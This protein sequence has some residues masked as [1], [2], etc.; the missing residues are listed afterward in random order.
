DAGDSS[1][2]SG[3]LFRA[4]QTGINLNSFSFSIESAYGLNNQLFEGYPANLI[5]EKLDST[6]LNDSLEL[7]MNYSGSALSTVDYAALPDTVLIPPGF[8]SISFP[9]IVFAD[10]LA[11]GT[12][13]L[14]IQTGFPCPF[15]NKFINAD[16]FDIYSLIGGIEPEIIQNCNNGL[17][18]IEASANAVDSMIS[19]LWSNGS[20]TNNM[21]LAQA[22]GFS[23]YCSVTITHSDGFTITDSVLVNHSTLIEPTLELYPD[24]CNPNSIWTSVSGGYPP[25]SFNWNIG[26]TNQSVLNPDNGHFYLTVTDIFGCSASSDIEVNSPNPFNHGISAYSLCSDSLGHLQAWA[27][28]GTSPYTFSWGTG[29]TTNQLDSIVAGNYYLTITDTNGCQATDSIINFNPSPLD[30]SLTYQDIG[31]T[32]GFA[33]ISIVNA[34][35]PVQISWSNGNTV[36]QQIAISAPGNYSIYLADSYGCEFYEGFG[37][38]IDSIS[39]IEIGHSIFVNQCDSLPG[40]IDITVLSGISPFTFDWSE[41][42]TTEDIFDLAYGEY[43]LTVTDNSSCNSVWNFDLSEP[44]ILSSEIFADNITDCHN[45]DNGS[46]ICSVSGGISPYSFLWSNG[47]T[48]ATVDSLQPGTHYVTIHDAC[49]STIIDSIYLEYEYSVNYNVIVTNASYIDPYGSI[50]VN[51]FPPTQFVFAQVQSQSGLQIFNPGFQNTIWNLSPGTYLLSV[52]DNFQCIDTTY[53]EVGYQPNIYAISDTMI[54]VNCP[55]DLIQLSANFFTTNPLGNESYYDVD[56]VPFVFEDTTFGNVVPGIIIDNT[57]SGPLPIEFGFNFFGET[58]T[59]FYVGSNGWISFQALSDPFY[60]PWVTQPIPNPDPSRPRCCVMAAYRDWDLSQGGEIKYYTTGI[61]PNRKLVVSFINIP[62]F[63]L[64]NGTLS[65]FQIVLKESSNTILINHLNVNANP[66]W[67]SGNGVSG[68]QNDLGTIA[69]L[70][71][72]SYNN[73]AFVSNST[74]FQFKPNQLSWYDPSQNLIDSGNQVTYVPIDEGTYTGQLQTPLGVEIINFHLYFDETIATIDLGPDIEICPYS[75]ELLQ[76]PGGY[77]YLWGNGD[78][79][80]QI[81]VEQAGNYYVTVSTEF[82]ELEDSVAV[83]FENMEFDMFYEPEVCEGDTV[84]TLCDSLFSY[85]WEN[86]NTT[87]ILSTNLTDTFFVTVSSANC[88]VED[89]VEIVLSPLPLPI[90]ILPSDTT[91]CPGQNL[92]LDGGDEPFYD[93]QWSHGYNN[94]YALIDSVGLYTLTLTDTVGCVSIDSVW[95]TDQEEAI[96][97]FNFFEAFNH[98]QFTNQSQNS[99]WYTWNFG[100]GSPLSYQTNPEHD[101]PVLNQNMWYIA[102]LISTNQCGADTSFLQIFTFDIEEI[103]E[104]PNIQIYPNPNKGTFFLTGNLK[105]NGN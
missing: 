32:P 74:S 79:N 42:S 81:T 14:L 9:I 102:T 7:I 73:T 98:V 83:S 63:Y 37:I 104:N 23:Q 71:D 38:A 11:E 55:G 101:Y 103:G 12:E 1:I 67:N 16:I 95:V 50:E 99:Y 36:D 49:N 86:G 105:S 97:N 30:V 44:G 69:Y 94:D 47:D 100:D 78:T 29:A 40:N 26:S 22:G 85:L 72:Q 57:Y 13:N 65:S 82:C 18:Y 52:M 91:K 8:M 68:I 90:G 64:I 35:G 51:F 89:T 48:T 33:E 28:F 70:Y 6:N 34:N 60:D 24:T 61:A 76:I 96:A 39:F 31:C 5:V 93:Y 17:V 46:A 87:N 66:V 21:V 25:Y 10:S 4:K 75:T 56:T 3:V 84:W 62:L 92:F 27:D 41:G 45:M 59:E 88:T 58:Y 54:L 15:N 43:F 53:V 19:Y 80:N 2:D 77:E 20:T